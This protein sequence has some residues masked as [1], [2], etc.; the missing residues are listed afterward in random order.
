MIEQR[1]G[2]SPPIS[3]A[4]SSPIAT[5]LLDHSS[6]DP[7]GTNNTN[8]GAVNSLMHQHTPEGSGAGSSPPV[9]A[10]PSSPIEDEFLEHQNFIHHHANGNSA[11]AAAAAVVALNSLIHQHS[12]DN[13]SHHHHHH[14]HNSNHNSS[15]NDHIHNNGNNSG[16]NVNCD[17]EIPYGS[18]SS[19]GNGGGSCASNASGGSSNSSNSS[20]NSN[21]VHHHHNNHHHPDLV[22]PTINNR[23]DDATM[24]MYNALE[25]NLT[26]P[27]TNQFIHSYMAHQAELSSSWSNV[28]GLEDVK[29]SA[30]SFL[31]PNS[32]L[33]AF[34]HAAPRNGSLL[35][36]YG[37]QYQ[38][39]FHWGTNSY[40]DIGFGVGA[41]GS[42]VNPSNISGNPT[43]VPYNVPSYTNIT[44]QASRSNKAQSN[45]INGPQL[46]EMDYDWCGPESRECVNCGA[47]STPLWRR[48]G[49]GHY[50]CNACGLYHKMNGTNRPLI[51][52]PKRI[53]ASRREGTQCAN[54]GTVKTSLWRRN[55]SGENVCNACGLYFKL[56]NVNRPLTMKKDTIQTRKRKPKNGASNTSGPNRSSIIA[57]TSSAVNAADNFLHYR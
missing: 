11:A 39:D 27:Y 40:F 2:S 33:P 26:N 45:L 52:Q 7:H 22:P 5:E 28:S 30:T 42:A 17:T 43:P 44:S 29:P 49:T 18:A 38:P 31:P 55:Q 56:H 8:T 23:M 37:A 4:P 15:N 51:K 35:H 3:G 57:H 41:P 47:V 1:A 54:C 16:N 34:I 13:H 12:P 21:S 32:K 14:H 19:Y 48:D 50:L 36:P 24:A 25:S 20:N 10:A 46:V 6:F 53:S 9:S